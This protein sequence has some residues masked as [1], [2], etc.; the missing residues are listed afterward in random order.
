MATVTIQQSVSLAEPPV[1]T[2]VLVL[3]PSKEEPTFN[4]SDIKRKYREERDKRLHARPVGNEQYKQFNGVFSKYLTY[5]YTPRVER[6]PMDIETD[7]LVFGGGFGELS[8]GARLME[9]GVTNMRIMDKAG[10]FGGTWYCN[11]GVFQAPSISYLLRI[12]R[13]I[14]EQP[15]ILVSL[16]AKLLG[17]SRG[18]TLIDRGLYLHASSRRDWLYT[19]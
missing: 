10:D 4:A 19:H 14:L 15:A 18:L 3:A 12:G 7:F 11:V 8:V 17:H 13:D 2:S 6:E 5:S 16:L 9:A 1:I